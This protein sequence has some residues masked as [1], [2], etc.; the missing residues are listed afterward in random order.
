MR[1]FLSMT[2]NLGGMSLACIYCV[3]HMWACRLWPT[4]AT[5]QHCFSNSGAEARNPD[6]KNSNE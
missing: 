3:G 2:R 4:I 5:K 6:R 1:D